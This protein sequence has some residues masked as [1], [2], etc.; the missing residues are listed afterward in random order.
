MTHQK[1]QPRRPSGPK[2][3]RPVNNP[4]LTVFFGS[5]T[6][7]TGKHSPPKMELFPSFSPNNVAV[8]LWSGESSCF[9]WPDCLHVSPSHLHEMD[10]VTRP[11]KQRRWL[12][13]VFVDHQPGHRSTNALETGGENGSP[14]EKPLSLSLSL[15]LSLCYSFVFLP[16]WRQAQAS[17][18]EKETTA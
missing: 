9:Q 16:M 18:S 11:L 8:S 3:G 7:S 4:L 1:G 14:A 17:H 5:L 6:S 13:V 15:S 12:L 10:L 2:L